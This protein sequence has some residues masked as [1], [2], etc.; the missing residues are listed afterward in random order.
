M[1]RLKTEEIRAAIL[2]SRELENLNRPLAIKEL[3]L[4]VGRS[5][6]SIRPILVRLTHCRILQRKDMRSGIEKGEKWGVYWKRW[7]EDYA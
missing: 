6:A 1:H 7:L 5:A 3:P 2:I 4:V